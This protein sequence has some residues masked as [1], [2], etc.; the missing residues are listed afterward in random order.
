MKQFTKNGNNKNVGHQPASNIAEEEIGPLGSAKDV[1]TP[2]EV[3]QLFVKDQFLEKIDTN[4]EEFQNL[5]IDFKK[6]YN[7]LRNIPTA[8][9]MI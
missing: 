8:K 2:L 5:E 6:R 4:T 1:T 3:W 7:L 9:Q